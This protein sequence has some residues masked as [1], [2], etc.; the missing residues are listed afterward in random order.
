MRALSLAA[1]VA[2]A[3]TPAFAGSASAKTT[4]LHASL[5]G[6]EEVPAA[7]GGSASA[8]ITLDSTK[9]KVCWTFT[10]IKGFSGAN[11][12]HIHVGAKGKAG[13]VIVPFG[14]AFKSKGCQTSISKSVIGAIRAH[15]GRYYVNI[16]NSQFPAGVVRGQLKK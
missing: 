3:A 9:K 7:A 2:L 14:S 10:K 13:D 16:H 8:K 6:S 5:K 4:T 11:A 1:L 12:A 15:P